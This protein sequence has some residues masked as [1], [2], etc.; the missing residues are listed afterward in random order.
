MPEYRRYLGALLPQLDT[1]KQFLLSHV[2]T[3]THVTREQEETMSDYLVI[4]RVLV[5]I[6]RNQK[7]KLP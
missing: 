6:P 5:H 4:L 7:Q 1:R 3:G 2:Q